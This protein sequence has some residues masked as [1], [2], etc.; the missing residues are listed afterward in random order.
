MRAWKSLKS[1]VLGLGVGLG[2]ACCPAFGHLDAAS[3][4]LKDAQAFNVG[5]TVTITWKINIP[6]QGF[7]LYLSLDNGSTWTAVKENL[8]SNS[9]SVKWLVPDTVVGNAKIRVYQ[10]EQGH[11]PMSVTDNWNLVSPAFSIQRPVTSLLPPS[12]QTREEFR[13]RIVGG[14]LVLEWPAGDGGEV[15]LEACTSTGTCREL[16]SP[17]RDRSNRKSASIP[18]EQLVQGSAA[19]ILVRR[20]NR[21]LQMLKIP[22]N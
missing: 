21:P 17:I 8:P 9:T 5:D 18:M 16:P 20:P 3:Y 6:H 13:S 15:A 11:P 1:R 4:S 10:F 2:L 12:V 14:V 22:G 19:W 7:T